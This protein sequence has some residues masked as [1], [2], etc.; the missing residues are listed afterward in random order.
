MPEDIDRLDSVRGLLRLALP[1]AAGAG[2]GYFMHFINRLVLSWHSTEALAAAMPAGFLAWTVQG[3]FIM[4]AAYVGTFAAQHHGAG[5]RREAGAMVWPMVAL[6]AV[7]AIVSLALIPARHLLA[8][9]FGTEPA[10]EAAMSELFGWYMAE[11]GLI[12]LSSGISGFFVGIGRPAAAMVMAVAGCA[13]S[14]ALNRWLV[15]G[16][17]GVPAL[18]VTGAGLATLITSALVATGWWILLMGRSVRDDYAPWRM[19][20]LDPAR[21]WRFN[22]YAIPRGG[23]EILEMVGFM[24][25]NAAITR[26]GTEPL[27]AHN[28]VFSVYL[29]VMVPLLGLLNGVSVAVGQAMGAGRLDAARSVTRRGV[30]IAAGVVVIAGGIMVAA[31]Q[32]VLAPYVAIDPADPAASQARWDRLLALAAAI[33][34]FATLGMLADAIQFAF[35]CGIQGAGD[36]RW[37]L[38]V[39]SGCAV[40]LMGAPALAVSHLVAIGAWPDWA[41]SPLLTCWSVFAVYVWVIAVVMWARWRWGPW[42]R[43]SVRA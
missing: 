40:L 25:F 6:S 37:P 2:L 16:G 34:P 18:G 7:A 27:A 5:E 3:F 13:V 21:L 12:V 36:T 43:M 11:T 24:L 28:L 8:G 26:L 1:F 14:I 10:V 4:S 38:A 32:L 33:M 15:L 41:P 29:V 39:L 23:T 20:N 19:R 35:R 22:R 9:L 31:P 42:A 30:Y 17:L